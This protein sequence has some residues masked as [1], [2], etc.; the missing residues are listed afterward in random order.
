M[1]NNFEKYNDKGLTGLANLGNT[2]FMNTVLQS[3]SHTYE[4]NDY[5]NSIKLDFVLNKQKNESIILSEWKELL[6]LMWSQN[7]VIAPKKFLIN[8]HKVA[9]I[10]DRDIFTG[11]AQNDL[12]EFLLFII[13]CFHESLCKKVNINI[14]GVPENKKDE[15]AIDSYKCIKNIFENDYSKIIEL[16]YGVQYSTIYCNE[17]N[18]ELQRIHEP[19]GIL[20]LPIPQNQQKISLYDCFD[21]YTKEEVLGDENKW[22]DTSTNIEYSIKK[23][24]K[25]FNLPNILIIDLKRFFN[26]GRK[27]NI[28]IN[29]ELENL[30]LSKYVCGYQKHK[31]IYDL[32]SICN[33]TGSNLG[34]HYYAYIKNSNGK[35]YEF[36]DSNVKEIENKNLITYHAYCLFYRKKEI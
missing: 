16:F 17:T 34:G 33:H 7:C 8:I 26:N 3:L 11:F 28:L 31:Y 13:D 24:I 10:K 14:L 36:N 18:K 25:F 30:D 12:P 9:K 5:L 29:I 21:E 35:W 15:L 2:C 27:N 4:L 22:T 19:F 23:E 32:Y 6:D 1:N 20:N